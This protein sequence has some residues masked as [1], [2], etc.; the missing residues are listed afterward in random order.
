MRVLIVEAQAIPIIALRFARRYTMNF[1]C[2]SSHLTL[3]VGF[4]TSPELAV[5]LIAPSF[6]HVCKLI[7]IKSIAG[8]IQRERHGF[9][10]WCQP[11]GTA[12]IVHTTI[13]QQDE[14]IYFLDGS[15][16]FQPNTPHS[17]KRGLYR[18]CDGAHFERRGLGSLGAWKWNGDGFG[19]FLSHRVPPNHPSHGWPRLIIETYGDDPF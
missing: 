7:C 9:Q 11:C 5:E 15:S 12:N 6:R 4:R 1:E 10:F 8:S 13:I 17:E 14:K 18:K 19:G 3:L 16:L 2:C